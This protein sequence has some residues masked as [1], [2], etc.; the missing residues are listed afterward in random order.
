MKTDNVISSV[1]DT[2]TK[3]VNTF[4]TEFCEVNNLSENELKNFVHMVVDTETVS[5]IHK[6]TNTPC[7]TIRKIGNECVSELLLDKEKY[8][9]TEHFINNYKNKNEKENESL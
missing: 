7:L 8:V 4:L 6:Q 1:A 3:V 5:I 2:A 9:K